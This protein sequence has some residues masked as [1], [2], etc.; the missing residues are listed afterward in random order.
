ME[1]VRA[2]TAAPSLHNSQPWRFRIG[3]DHVDVYAD[4]TRQLSILDPLGRELMVSVG[5][6]LFTLRLA[7][8][9]AGYLPVLDLFPSGDD[10][11][12]VSRVWAGRRLAPTSRVASLAM[13]VE[14]RHT[15][16]LP[17]ARAA[18]PASAVERLVVAAH[19]EGAAL[20]LANPVGRDAILGMSRAADRRLRG[21][22]GYDGE[23]ARWTGLRNGRRDGVPRSAIGPSDALGVL[24]IRD[25][26]LPQRDSVEFEP[27]PAIAVLATRGDGTAQWVKSG[28]ALQ[29]VLLTATG[30]GL[31]TTPISQP[32]E[33]PAVRSLLTDTRTG[34]WAQMVLRI[35]YGRPVPATPRRPV[36]DVLLT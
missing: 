7:I 8:R 25:F 19:L 35:G 1:C 13:A 34:T 32:V 36:T 12:L 27:H 16:R 26:A 31:A 20:A 17:F 22:Y 23:L 6:A 24:P 5:A 3:D 14:R 29:R 4:S 21:R 33:V 11:R 15:N 10:S 9:N 30:L 28:Q 2:A 18:L